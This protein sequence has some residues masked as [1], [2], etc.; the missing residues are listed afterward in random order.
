MLLSRRVSSCHHFCVWSREGSGLE[1]RSTA[2]HVVTTSAVAP[3]ITIGI[4]D[5]TLAAPPTVGRIV[6]STTPPRPVPTLKSTGFQSPHTAQ[7]NP[8]TVDY[9]TSTLRP[10]GV[11]VDIVSDDA[12]VPPPAAG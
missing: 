8:G 6:S 7:P 12:S 1:Q 10:P 3:G 5:A 4:D 9:C 2:S 11:L